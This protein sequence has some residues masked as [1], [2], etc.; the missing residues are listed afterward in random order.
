MRVIPVM[1]FL[2]F[3]MAIFP[4]GVSAQDF[5]QM[6]KNKITAEYL[7][8]EKLFEKGEYFQALNHFARIKE[9]SNGV[10][11]PT[12][13]V[14]EIKT[15]IGLSRWDIAARELQK[16]FSLEL[17]PEILSEV[18]D[19][20]SKIAL[21]SKCSPPDGNKDPDNGLAACSAGCD[22]GIPRNC[23]LA[24]EA[25][26]P[27]GLGCN[28]TMLPDARTTEKYARLACDG[29]E[30]NGCATLINIM[31]RCGSDSPRAI[32]NQGDAYCREGMAGVCQT[33][34][35]SVNNQFSRLSSLFSD[36][37]GKRLKAQYGA[38][39]KQLRDARS[40]EFGARYKATNEM[41]GIEP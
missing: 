4:A 38:R 26:Y 18:S 13:K 33:L 25:A 27:M 21:N 19:I 23:Y 31:E 41:Y 9:L 35:R 15:L 36:S 20:N 40:A 8:A 12:A 6:T 3:V 30:T 22:A 29:G 11:L 5:D 28:E 17:S 34:A 37:E 14:L 16:L 10:I 39:S 24:A 32:Y 2:V 7:E 1:I